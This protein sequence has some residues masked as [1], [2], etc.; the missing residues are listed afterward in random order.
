M[1]ANVRKRIRSRPGTSVGS[2]SAAA[3]ETAPR[4]PAQEMITGACHGGY[5]SR[6]R[7]LRKSSR[8]TYVKIGTKM[9]R[10]TTTATATIAASRSS[11]PVTSRRSVMPRSCRP[12]SAKSSALTR[13]VRISQNEL[14]ESLVSTFVSW[15]VYQPM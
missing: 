6:S 5:G 3:S 11:V 9:R 14:P 15:G 8:G 13:N 1:T 7:M 4:K 2:A 10:I 12:T